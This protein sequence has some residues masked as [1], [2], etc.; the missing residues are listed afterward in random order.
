M[1]LRFVMAWQSYRVGDVIEPTGMFRDH[2]MR[3]RWNGRPFVEVVTEQ[4]QSPQLEQPE[5]AA[6]ALA[7]TQPQHRDRKRKRGNP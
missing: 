2:I 7:I 3:M 6:P 5:Q 4:P 1:K